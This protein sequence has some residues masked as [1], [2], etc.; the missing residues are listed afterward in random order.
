MELWICDKVHYQFWEKQHK[1]LTLVGREIRAQSYCMVVQ[2]GQALLVVKAIYTFNF[3]QI[4]GNGVLP[5]LKM[6]IV[7]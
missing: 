2:T 5:E 3:S 4:R 7:F 1:N 6:E